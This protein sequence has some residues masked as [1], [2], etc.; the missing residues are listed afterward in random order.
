[1]GT[2][3]SQAARSVNLNNDTPI[4]E[5]TSQQV[6]RA[7]TLYDG[8]QTR[9]DDAKRRYE[10]FMN[11]QSNTD[12]IDFLQTGG[13]TSD[14]RQMEQKILWQN[15]QKAQLDA[16]QAQKDY[17]NLMK[18][19]TSQIANAENNSY[20]QMEM[21]ELEWLKEYQKKAVNRRQTEAIEAQNNYGL[22]MNDM[23]NKDVDFLEG[24]FATDEH[25]RQQQD[26]LDSAYVA[27]KSL[28]TSRESLHLMDDTYNYRYDMHTLSKMTNAEKLA[29]AMYGSRE[30]P[31]DF[32][33]SLTA[34]QRQQLRNSGQYQQII[35]DP[36][37]YL[38][39]RG[40][41]KEN[42]ARLSESYSRYLNEQKMKQVQENAV[43][44]A[45]EHPLWAAVSTYPAEFIGKGLAA[46]T[47]ISSGAASSFG[48]SGYHSL[49]AN[50]PGYAHLVYS[51]TIRDAVSED[52]NN[53]QELAYNN[54]NTAADEIFSKLAFK[55]ISMFP[56]LEEAG[57]AGKQ[58]YDIF[59]AY[60][61]TAYDAATGGATANESTALAAAV[62]GFD[63]LTSRIDID[64]LLQIKSSED[65][66]KAA[67]LILDGVGNISQ[68]KLEYIG[69]LVIETALLAEDCNFNQ[70][71][72]AL[73]QT[74][75]PE[76]EA[77]KSVYKKH[78][79]EIE[80]AA[81]LEYGFDLLLGLD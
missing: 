33:N 63:W 52:F 50:H 66:A 36:E 80:Y 65:W 76:E 16:D 28:V 35:K 21:D 1:M 79:S 59:G 73:V 32:I 62:A 42:L 25:I 22:Y 31:I 51:D 37:T 30:Y 14:L 67:N 74:G 68:E 41:G 53:A 19:Y 38:K 26:L 3:V 11:Q 29:L 15:Y 81:A 49:D 56:G 46:L 12:D 27:T 2:R 47:T 40:Y 7:K 64:N 24:N 55:G 54:V 58:I 4:K 6:K 20:Q 5:S 57:N 44:F 13:I 34:D 71:V 17:N 72:E 10:S 45:E 18:Q 70:Q 8:A 9:L 77:K 43:H 75:V 23:M 78:I 61:E 48:L 60:G 69:N 39:H